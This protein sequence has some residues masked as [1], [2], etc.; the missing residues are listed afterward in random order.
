MNGAGLWGRK[1]P[2][3][4]KEVTIIPPGLMSP[5]GT[6]WQPFCCAGSWSTL[7]K[8]TANPRSPGSLKWALGLQ[9]LD[10]A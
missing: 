1:L 9:V 8:D 7:Q 4:L 3:E 2:S 6:A 10:A 5:T